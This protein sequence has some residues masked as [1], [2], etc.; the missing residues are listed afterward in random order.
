MKLA[1]LVIDMLKD[2]IEGPLSSPRFKKVIPCISK[3]INWAREKGIPVIYVNDSHIPEVDR[4]LKLWGPHAIRG[5]PGAEV[6]SELKPSEKD[7]VVLKRRYSGFYATE[8]DTLL[9]ELSVDTLVLTGISTDVCVL[10]TAADAFFRNYELIVV[11][12]CVEAF[13]EEGHRWALEYMKKI[14]GAKIMKSEE[15]IKEFQNMQTNNQFEP[16]HS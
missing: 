4:E 5:S 7:F 1:I 13:T 12:D 8:L 3:L 6:I 9:R 15:L 14:Y 11:E 16:Q 10:H 2:F